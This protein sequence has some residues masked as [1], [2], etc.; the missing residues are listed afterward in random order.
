[1]SKNSDEI[2]LGIDLG[3][4]FSVCGACVN[5][6]PEIIPNEC[7]LSL[8][9]SIVLFEDEM[10]SVAGST[11]EVYSLRFR[12]S[13]IS[14]MKRVIGLKYD[15]ISDSKKKFFPLGLKKDEEGKVKILV[16]FTNN[17]R[18]KLKRTTALNPN[19]NDEKKIQED[20]RNLK[21]I[22]EEGNCN[23]D[24]KKEL[25]EFYPENICAQILKSFKEN[26]ESYYDKH[27][28]KAI[29][30]VPA[31][32]S[33]EQRECTQQA[34]EKAGLEVI[35]LINEPTAAA[36]A[37]IYHYKNDF[38]KEKK[39]LVFDMG[40][41]TCDITTLKTSFIDG[42]IIIKILST[43]G[44]QNLGGHDFDN[45][46]MKKFLNINNF[47]D[48][49]LKKE[50]NSLLKFRLKRVIE[51]A[52]KLLSTQDKVK[53]H[54]EKFINLSFEKDLELT[55]SNFEDICKDLFEKC[56][57]LIIKC[58]NESGLKSD[59]F[60][61]VILVGGSSKIPKNKAILKEIFKKSKIH[62]EIDPDTIV[63]LGAAILGGKQLNEKLN[64]ENREFTIED[65]V[66]KSLGIEVNPDKKFSVLIPKNSTIPIEESRKFETNHDN[67]TEI[68]IRVFEG[69]EKTVD[70]N[71]K[72]GEF[73]LINLPEKPKGEVKIDVF[74][75][76]NVNGI[77]EV[78]AKECEKEN[79]Y[80]E[81]RIVN[82]KE[83]SS[84]MQINQNVNN[85]DSLL[86][87]TL[88]SYNK[89]I[90]SAKEEEKF[91]LYLKLINEIHS[92]FNEK[93]LNSIKND[94][95]K[96]ENFVLQIQI[97]FVQYSLMFSYKK[98]NKDDEIIKNIKNH[99]FKY[100]KFIIENDDISLL[101]ISEIIENLITNDYIY[102]FST[103]FISQKYFE[104]GE[105]TIKEFDSIKGE[106]SEDYEEKH[107]KIRLAI[108]YLNEGKNRLN[109]QTVIETM[110]NISKEIKSYYDN[111]KKKFE[112]YLIKCDIKENITYCYK[113]F[114]YVKNIQIAVTEKMKGANQWNFTAYDTYLREQKILHQNNDEYFFEKDYEDLLKIY[115]AKRIINNLFKEFNCISDEEYKK[116]ENEFKNKI[117][118]LKKNSKIKSLSN[119]EI[120]DD[121]YEIQNQFVICKEK[122]KEDYYKF[123]E[124]VFN[125]YNYNNL[126]EKKI[127]EYLSNY[128]SLE[129]KSNW[130]DEIK[131]IYSH[132]NYIKDLKKNQIATKIEGYLNKIQNL[133]R[134]R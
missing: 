2:I 46:L 19:K 101:N 130:I 93:Y 91:N 24:T 41:G 20:T 1:M 43:A 61:D 99:I 120:Q 118:D 112:I 74:F 109:Y 40:A 111:L 80:N 3:T 87:K 56:K 107:Q 4:D 23:L 32:F 35:Q 103:L 73:N 9:P 29:I 15:E 65:V 54:L 14:E 27:I 89:E 82:H 90:S 59:D 105:K 11:A 96:I 58:V 131:L 62:D 44:D 57:N 51:K 42:K 71:K 108:F 31:D 60:D 94:P 34:G 100:L 28:K 66:S 132:N 18:K 37:Y 48:D 47:N 104:L 49:D 84:K 63:A 134:K 45:L 39:L 124:F 115:Y 5:G 21:G 110:S 83:I 26:A 128:K 55:R 114:A 7:G 125:K 97:L 88:I 33:N 117:D 113:L 95:K 133:Y 38:N 85:Y 81:I 30:T 127:K 123:F 102:N 119:M 98:L 70:K 36:L 13:T 17:F 6:N 126:S 16:N 12:D 129:D 53:I 122:Y 52:K 25:K 79:N 10:T 50:E 92:K 72:L 78:T 64:K 106:E 76:I 22:L 69:E 121:I 86:S 77:L 67:Q 68:L 116:T 75:K 8:S